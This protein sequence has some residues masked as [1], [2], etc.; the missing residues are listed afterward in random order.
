MKLGRIAVDGPDGPV[1]RLVVALP[2]EG[3]VIDLKRA[4]HD[5]V[6]KSGGTREAALRLAS[7]LFPGSMR[8]A[9]ELGPRFLAAARNAHA[10][11]P[12]AASLPI[13]QVVWL[14]ATDPT[15][16]WRV[17]KSAAESL[18]VAQGSPRML[19]GQNAEIARPGEI[20]AVGA[21]PAL[22][23]IVGKRGQNIDPAEAA[24]F[25]FGVA[26]YIGFTGTLGPIAGAEG[27]AG[28]LKCS[29]F[30]SSIGPWITT[31]DE[32]SDPHAIIGDVRVNGDIWSPGGFDKS[33]SNPADLVAY[34]SLGAWLHPGDILVSGSFDGA[35]AASPGRHLLP[36]DSIEVASDGVGRLRNSIGRLQPM[37]G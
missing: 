6:V 26:L 16:V 7:A 37:P 27:D 21:E 5:S 9:I 19:L 10:E 20:G 36:G 32:V 11:R 13:D 2:E 18:H 33:P 4:A 23:W 31:M 12:E 25:V 34:A 3:R 24:N 30:A 14:P 22:G 28:P 8:E 29:N 35:S 17:P 15:M 1:S